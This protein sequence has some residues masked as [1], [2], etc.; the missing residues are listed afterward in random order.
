VEVLIERGQ[1]PPSWY[2]EEPDYPPGLD[3]YMRAFWQLST[4]R[5][6]GFSV[7]PIPVS[8]I[9]EFGEKR[10]YDPITL[11]IFRHLIREVDAAYLDWLTKE[12]E[13]KNRK[14]KR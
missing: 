8:K 11:D 9:E 6:I 14:R 2:E 7:G 13:K 4:E 10:G 12:R 5:Q 3:F 1:P